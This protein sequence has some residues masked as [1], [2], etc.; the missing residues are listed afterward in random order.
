MPLIMHAILGLKAEAPENRLRVVNPRLPYW[1][2]SVLVRGLRVGNG[3]VT[4]L[5]RRDGQDTRVEV[6]EATAGLDVTFSQ[7]WPL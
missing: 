3:N 1:L 6:Q 4:L 7:H 2:N 5:Y